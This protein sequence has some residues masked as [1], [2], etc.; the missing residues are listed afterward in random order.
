MTNDEKIKERIRAILRKAEDAKGAGDAERDTAM[1]MAQRLLLKHGLEMQDVGPAEDDGR[2]FEHEGFIS[3]EG[4]DEQWKG[5]LLHRLAPTYFCKVYKLNLGRKAHHRWVII[6]RK[7]NTDALRQMYGFIWPQI[8]GAFTVEV[9]RMGLYWRH[10]RRYAIGAASYAD[11]AADPESLSDAELAELGEDRLD[12]F[13]QDP[14][15][16]EIEDVVRLCR[17]SSRG[18]AK[19]VLPRIRKREIAPSLSS[20][21]GVWRRSFLDAAVGRVAARVAELHREEVQDLGTPGTELVTSEALDLS[22]FLESLDLGLRRT[23]SSRQVD[24][25]GRQSGR[26]AGDRADISGHRKVSGNRKV[27]G[28]GS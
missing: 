13:T 27:L 9:S 23:R 28:P 24:G 6:G 17:L 5:V 16:D 7:D 15:L 12:R 10:A 18:Y 4:R 11:P 25:A 2:S 26:A 1:R 19:N 20:N 3:T 22:R 21:L 14:D 8:E